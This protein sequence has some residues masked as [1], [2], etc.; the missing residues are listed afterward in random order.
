MSVLN[1]HSVFYW[2]WNGICSLLATDECSIH[3]N[4][5][6]N[7]LDI[8]EQNRFMNLIFM[9]IRINERLGDIG[10]AFRL[11]NFYDKKMKFPVHFSHCDA[12][13]T[14]ILKFY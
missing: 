14:D 5:I 13:W 8:T 4:A 3:F 10:Y 1:N 12:E 9:L 7:F 6:L 2:L 11:G